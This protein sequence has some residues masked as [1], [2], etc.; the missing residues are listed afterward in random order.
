MQ[1]RMVL[2]IGTTIFSK[3]SKCRLLH[4]KVVHGRFPAVIGPR[5]ELDMGRSRSTADEKSI[6]KVLRA[7]L[8]SSGL[9]EGYKNPSCD[10]I[11]DSYAD[12]ILDLLDLSHTINKSALMAATKETLE[13]PHDEANAFAGAI[14]RAI[15]SCQEKKK[16]MKTG[17]KLS[18]AVRLICKKLKGQSEA[19]QEKAPA[20]AAATTETATEATSKL[21]QATATSAAKLILTDSELTRMFGA[22]SKSSCSSEPSADPGSPIAISSCAGSPVAD[23]TP[24]KRKFHEQYLHSAGAMVRFAGGQM[25]EQAEMAAGPDGFQIAIWPSG[26]RCVT[27]VPNIVREELQH[28]LKRPAAASSKKPAAATAALA[29]VATA[30]APTAATAAA[31]SSSARSSARNDRPANFWFE[32]E[33]FGRCKAEF[34]E[35]KSYARYLK[36][37]GGLKLIVSCEKLGHA[38]LLQS[39]IPEIKKPGQTS[40]AMRSLRDEMQKQES[41]DVN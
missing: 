40:E 35:A 37:D 34:Y 23:T 12:F 19:Q 31:P 6:G 39:L 15:S 27:E 26:E 7:N 41:L 33:S 13:V 8:I 28:P 22:K 38:I 21:Q 36:D 30:T 20:A 32:S 18:E 24:R 25:Q 16:S 29:A 14:C 2:K 3:C 4:V 10:S 9:G 5:L 17:K 11:C 1:C